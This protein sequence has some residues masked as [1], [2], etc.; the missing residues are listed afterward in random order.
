MPTG[1]SDLVDQELANLGGQFGQ[2]RLGKVLQISGAADLFKHQASLR[3]AYRSV[4]SRLVDVG[5]AVVV[6]V[7]V[8]ICQIGR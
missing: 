1:G 3:T 6:G 7:A 2:L 4:L 5:H 8:S